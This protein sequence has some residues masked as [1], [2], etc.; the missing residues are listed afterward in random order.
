MGLFVGSF[1]NVVIYRLPRRE[2]VVWPPSRCP[3]CGERL[4]W[5]DLIPV[6]SY[7]ILRGRCRHC[8]GR[9]SP[10]YPAVELLTAGLFL[11]VYITL[12]TQSGGGTGSGARFG[13]VVAKNLFFTAALLAAAF[14]DAEHRIIPNRLVLW[15]AAGAVVLGPLAGDVGAA[16]AVAG[17][18]AVGCFLLL[19]SAVTGGGMGGGDIKFAA[20][21]GLYLGLPGVMLGLFIGALLGT[22]YGATLIAIKKKSGREPVP[23]G[24]FLSLGFLASN[25]W[26][27]L[28]LSLL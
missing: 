14:I 20:A 28:L 1:L 2:S 25:L 19:L 13:W 23:F 17:A 27:P 7:F 15:M 21:A 6:V 9:I 18:V 16:S 24:P 11:V 22:F 12:Q 8:G 4:Q 3:A 26:G 10:R 5:C